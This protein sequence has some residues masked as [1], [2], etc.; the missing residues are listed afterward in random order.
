[1]TDKPEWGPKPVEV[2]RLAALLRLL[3]ALLRSSD[4]ESPDEG[5]EADRPPEEP[6]P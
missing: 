1:M 4:E 6:A 3:R 5:P 2:G